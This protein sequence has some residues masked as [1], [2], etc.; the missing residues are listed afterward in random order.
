MLIRHLIQ[1]LS[2]MTLRNRS[3]YAEPDALARLIE[4]NEAIHRLNGHL[5]DLL[6]PDVALSESRKDGIIEQISLLPHPTLNRIFD[7]PQ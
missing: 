1:A 6:D 3:C 4:G 5:H 2:E 7:S